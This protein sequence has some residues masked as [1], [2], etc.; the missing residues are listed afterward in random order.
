MIVHQILKTRSVWIFGL[1]IVF[2]SARHASAAVT[3]A[4][5]V[6]PI[7]QAHCQECHRPGEGAPMSLLSYEEA[8]P[9]AKS[10][11]KAVETRAMPPWHADP[12]IGKWKNDRSLSQSEIETL[13]GWVDAGAPLGNPADL[14]PPRKFVTGWKNGEPDMI[15]KMPKEQVLSTDLDDE[16]RY[17]MIPTGLTEDRWVKSVEVRPGN[18]NVVHHVIIFTT[19]GG[20]LRKAAAERGAGRGLALRRASRGDGSTG[21]GGGLGG[22]APGAL[23]PPLADG[24]GI[25][26]PANSVLV[27]QMHYHKEKGQEATDRTSIGV[28]FCTAPVTHQLRSAPIMDRWLAIP[29]GDPNYEADSSFTVPADVT[30][31]TI[32][33]HMHLRG[34]D[35][36]VTAVYPNGQSKDL[37]FVPNYDFNWQTIYEAADPITVPKGTRLSVKAHFDNSA[38]NPHNPDPT[39]RVRW[40]QPTTSEMMIAFVGYELVDE[41]AKTALPD[42]AD[43]HVE[44]SGSGGN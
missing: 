26:L 14:P 15:F 29:P 11:K 21:V 33:P 40:G 10:I 27:L 4:K 30:I 42:E 3:F 24:Y 7:M 17:V 44:E 41:K 39:Q 20:A 36:R 37:L 32:M 19:N 38:G 13:V 6:A 23:R 5:E 35:M 43:P 16:H 1:L 34:K 31:R 22:Y 12:T 25:R 2:A 18:V 9:W 8:R 28:R